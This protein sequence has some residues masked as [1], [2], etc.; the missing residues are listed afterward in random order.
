MPNLAMVQEQDAIRGGARMGRQIR[1]KTI[2]KEEPNVGLYVLAL[3]ALVLF[4]R[5]VKN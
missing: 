5:L 3:I 2:K 4:R 1:V